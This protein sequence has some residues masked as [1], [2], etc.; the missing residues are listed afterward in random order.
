[1]YADIT[2]ISSIYTSNLNFKQI[3]Q[4]F[5]ESEFCKLYDVHAAWLFS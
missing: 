4:I 3:K 5:Q 1:M 2:R